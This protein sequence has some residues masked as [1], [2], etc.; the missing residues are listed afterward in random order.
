MY[1]IQYDKIGFSGFFQ[2]IIKAV[3]VPPIL[4]MI[5]FILEFYKVAIPVIINTIP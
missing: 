3:S 1:F 5:R 2:K 4:T